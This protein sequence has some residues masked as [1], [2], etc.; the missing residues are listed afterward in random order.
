MAAAVTVLTPNGR[1]QTVKVSPNTPLL[2]VTEPGGTR[3]DPGG[4]GE[5]H[6]THRTSSGANG[7]SASARWTAEHPSTPRALPQ[8]SYPSN[9]PLIQ[10][11]IQ[12]LIHPLIQT[13]IHPL[14]HPLSHPL[15][16]LILFIQ[17]LEDVCK[18]HEFNPDDHGLK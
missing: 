18:K 11:L 9:H 4:P 10:P 13:L 16:L 8:L 17:V 15:I 14:I 5:N 2:Q 6:P 1:R 12:P 7:G 3:G